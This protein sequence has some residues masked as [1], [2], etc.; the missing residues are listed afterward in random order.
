MRSERWLIL[1]F[2]ACGC[3]YE[4]DSLRYVPRD[5]A[6]D[7]AAPDAPADREPAD[8]RD[9]ADV[10]DAADVRDVSE[11]MD[12]RDAALDT[13]A[14]VATDAPRDATLDATPD[15]A[16]DAMPDAAPDAMP[17]A[18]PDAAPDVPPACTPAGMNCPC[19][20][21]NTGGYCRPGEACTGGRCM[22]GTL[23]GSLVITEIMNDPNATTDE[24]GEWVEVYNPGAT[25][26]DLRGLRLSNSRAQATTLP[27]TAPAAVIAPGG[28]AVLARNMVVGVTPLW[29]YGTGLAT[30][31]LTFSNSASG[32][33]VILDL[34]SSAMEIDR[35]T[36]SEATMW[37]NASGRARSL[38]PTA[39]NAAA[40]DMASSWCDAVVRWMPP[41]SDY[42]SP[43]A[44]NP[45][46]P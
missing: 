29:V 6:P 41:G 27:T 33:S 13:P 38:R 30:N 37:I 14:D 19:A 16:P 34:G 28:Y 35:V 8:V 1:A 42:G 32:D 31:T 17:D 25:P 23:A 4:W 15:A 7:R 40:N 45:A 12:V 39:L 24:V 26:L 20:T 21:T 10:R 3:S 46:C 44:A 2:V 43:G 18:M 36:Y 11:G 22:M 9:V 5:A